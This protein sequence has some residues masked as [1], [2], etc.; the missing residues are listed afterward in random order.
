MASLESIPTTIDDIIQR[1]NEVKVCQDHFKLITTSLARLRNELNDTV[2][3]SDQIHSKQ[4][5]TQILKAIHEIV[6]SCSQNENNLNGMTYNDLKSVLFRLQFRL[7]EHEANTKDDY[8]LRAEILSNAYQEQQ[9]LMQKSSDEMINERLEAMEKNTKDT[10]IEQL[11]LLREKY[12]K[13][14]E[15]YLRS[16]IELHQNESLPSEIVAKV[17]H[18]SYQISSED[19]TQFELSCTFPFTR[20]FIQL[21]PDNSTIFERNESQR[22]L[23]DHEMNTLRT[24]LIRKET[25]T[26]IWKQLL[27]TPYMMSMV[28]RDHYSKERNATEETIIRTKRWISILGDP[29]SG[30]TSF[31]QQ[32]V[33]QLAETF[34]L[35]EQYS[36]NYGP[37]RLPI[38]IRMSDVAEISKGQPSLTLFDYIGKHRWLKNSI[39][40]ESSIS[41]DN[42]CCALQEYVK[43]GQALII[44]DGLDQISLPNQRSKIV[45]MI[46]IFVDTYVQAPTNVSDFDN[47]YLSRLIDDPS[48]SGGN[49]IIITSRIVGYHAVPLAGQFVPYT[50]RSMNTEQIKEFIDDWFFHVHQQIIEVINAPLV[51][52]AEIHS[53]ALK[54]ELEKPE[55]VALLDMA[56]NIYLVSFLCTLCFNQLDDAPLPIQ[57]ILL[58]DKIINSILHLRINKD[59]AID[60]SKLIRILSDIA[61]Y[62]HE[63]SSLGLI[64]EEQIKDI[65]IQSIKTSFGKTLP[66]EE[67]H[68]NIESQA[69]EFVRII[70]E[71]TSLLVVRGESLYGFLHL[72][73]QDYFICLKLIEA[74]SS[75]QKKFITDG[76]DRENEIQRIAK[77]LHHHTN[78][79]RFRIPIALALGKI[80]SSWSQNDFDDLCY[81]F[82]QDENE[83]NSLIPLGAF[84]LIICVNDLVKF[85]SD[86][87]LFTALDRLI[88]VAGQQKWS[89]VCPFLFDQIASALKKFRND[90]IQ[91][92]INN[93]LSRSP[94]HD[95]QAISSLCHLIEGKPHEFENIKWLNPSSCSILQSLSILDSENNEF[96]IDRLLVKVAF[97]NHHL[98]PIDS[99]TFKGFLLEK[100][101]EVNSI[102]I[103]LFPLIITLYG[104]LNRN[105]Q[106]V[107]FNPSHIHRECSVLTPALIRFF[108]E[109]DRN[110]QDQNLNK[111]QQE[112]LKL[113]L[114]RIDNHDESPEAIDLCIA[115]IYFYNIEYIQDNLDIISNSLLRKSMNR[116]KYISMILR[117]FYFTADENDRLMENEATNFISNVIEKFQYV[118]TARIH[119]LDLLNSLRSS[120]ARLRSSSKSI[121]IEGVSNVDKRITLYLP[122]SLRTNKFLNRLLVA[123]IHFDSNTKSCSLLHQFT[124]LLWILEHNDELET[125]YRMAVAMDTIPEYLVFRNDEDLLFTLTFVPSHL[126]NL[127]IRLLK[128]NLITINSRNSRVNNRQHLYFGHILIECFILLSN[129]SC[130][131]LSIQ[132]AAI[133][134][135]PWFRMYNLEN[136]GSSLLWSLATKDSDTLGSFELKRQRSMNNETGRYE[137]TDKTPFSGTDLMDEQRTTLIQNNI[138]QEYERLQSTRM[139]NDEK[140]MKLYSASISLGHICRWAEDERRLSL[141]E[142]SI[143]GAMSIENKIARLDALCVI[144]FYAYVNFD[145]L[146]VSKDKSLEKEIEHQFN[147]IYPDLPLL[148]HAAMFLRCLP[149]LQHS[150]MIHHCL[151]N[152]FSKFANTDQRDQ[153]AVNEALLPYM[154][155]TYTLSP[156]T[157]SFSRTLRDNKKT[158]HNKSAV[159]KKCFTL[160]THENLSLTLFISNLFISELTNDLHD[161]VKTDN[162]EFN[163]DE[164]IVTK[165]FQVDNCILTDVQACTITNILTFAPLTDQSKKLEKLRIIFSNALHRMSWVE[166]KA[167]RLLESWLKWKDSNEL[168]TFAYHAAL[169]LSNSNIWSIEVA[170]ILC[171]LLSSD[172]DRFRHRAETIF[173]LSSY[174][175]VRT[176]S[177]LGIDILLT[178]FKKKLHYQ[179]T[180]ASAK[181]TL[182]RM[183]GS[184]TIDMQSHLETILWLERYRI[185][186]LSNPD[187]CLNKPRP[188]AKSYVSSY[189]ST[190]IPIDACS[191]VDLYRLSNDLIIYICDMIASSF[192]AYLEIDGDTTS[193]EVLESHTQFI[194]SVVLNLF[195]TLNT[196]DD[197]RQLAFEALMN[198]F[199]MSEKEN[200]R[201]AIAYTLG[202]V[203]NERT[204]KTLLER[205][206][207]AM[208]TDGH[209]N[210]L[211]TNNVLIALTSSYTYC[212]CIN[213]ITFDQDD[214][215]LFCSLLKHSSQDVV[216][217]ARTGLAR[218]LK[219]GS[220]LLDM[221]SFDPIQC[222]HALIGA[223]A[224]IFLYDVQQSSENAIA[225]FIEECPNL[226]PIFVF[227]LYD[228]IRHFT[229]K[230]LPMTDKEFFLAYACPQYVKVASLIAVRMPA[231]FCAFIKDWNDGDHLR[232]ALFYTSKQHNF[233]QRAAC[234]T[235]LSLLGELTVDLCEMFIEGLSDDP[236]IQNTCYNRITYIR[237]ITDEQVTVSLLF[238]Y[239]KSKS[240]NVRYWTAKILLH[241]C[242]LSLIP[243]KQVQI[244]LID[245]IL[246]PSSDEDLWL[247]EEQDRVFPQCM[248]YYAGRLKDVIF[249][250]LIQ[251]TIG[252][253]SKLVRRN[254]FND[255]DLD[256]IQSEKASRLASCLYEANNEKDIESEGSPTLAD[257]SDE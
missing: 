69:F 204:Y 27:S 183:V 53:D 238:S 131:R 7:I 80:S 202:Y 62:I 226:L 87:I 180:S 232:R 214:I 246:D 67:D 100:Q 236:Y 98:L 167:R 93:F 82:I 23:M 75:K 253:A 209:E 223:T 256:F 159:L 49:Q 149:L 197:T 126:R 12:P 10:I 144:A 18:I 162:R 133:A 32:I 34:L 212:V 213:T 141:L 157:N 240:M 252:N 200:I 181:L 242:Q 114:I 155:L 135:L 257:L 171:D 70:C 22:L 37:L 68:H 174:D 11:R 26:G 104:G 245:V 76:L 127:Y 150:Q 2:K 146:E 60:I 153:Q 199:D 224:Y 152:L 120:V 71:D 233:P 244:T 47:P 92:W 170:T 129:A 64:D 136:F 175:D 107:I 57:R 255:L 220:L 235:I 231:A 190:D 96:A 91:Q 205:T 225:E 195:T 121:F 142:Q 168:S 229:T 73:F 115:I 105:D 165:L 241:L 15:S 13:I 185:H 218:A 182:S 172:N 156:I 89:I 43:K 243:F 46:K 65:C 208:T 5:L 77:L 79:P 207:L 191:C 132:S 99:I 111:L 39:I 103:V 102:P 35:N 19:Q 54:K 78:D 113:F 74:D 143:N 198:L 58:Y 187:Y 222:Y 124:K 108:S 151:A 250:L 158:M 16:C 147:E 128:E 154:Q 24:T 134:L 117:Q 125:Q 59:S 48:R 106:S 110:R 86:E 88:I 247:I 194:A 248:Y 63:H 14:I 164:S 140:N 44:L 30:K 196:T 216:R 94:S 219:D 160:V 25:S 56:S 161:Y 52:Q 33:R 85:P 17:A 234:L 189:F 50:I 227:E 97:S 40:D 193:D 210:S 169:L 28:E 90:T 163:I 3:L 31:V 177:T 8:Q 42:L 112:C 254:E 36:T 215:D 178:L 137:D 118:E 61:I 249:S 123:N 179:L 184:I 206:V 66:N 45:D 201:Q 6:T 119:F 203:C 237:S 251:Q 230:V 138:K 9:L 83:S 173:R 166:L 186:A 228:S 217:A 1:A 38:L 116:L 21:K 188:W 109:Q 55:N 29:G 95:I 51:N 130:K 221:L 148:L 72:A 192:F 81:E 20:K 239:L 41:I 211:Y 101:I 122:N 139:E 176:S 145:K 4:D 84:M